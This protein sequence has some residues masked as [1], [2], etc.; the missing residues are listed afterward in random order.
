M[1]SGENLAMGKYEL[2]VGLK[3]AGGKGAPS[4]EITVVTVE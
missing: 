4:G 3:L 2:R 1:N